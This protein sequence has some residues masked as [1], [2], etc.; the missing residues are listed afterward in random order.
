M[1]M[2]E[3][4]WLEVRHAWRTLAARPMHTSL[5][6]LTL[7]LG[8]GGTAAIA[9]VAEEALLR[10]LPYE[11]DV[12]LVAFWGPEDWSAAD[13]TSLRGRFDG[14]DD[15]AAWRPEESTL[16]TGD[17]PA[18]LIST[19][20]G[21]S[22][23]FDVLGV[24]PVMGRAFR[25]G[26]D[27]AGAE[28][29]TVVSNG[30]WVR[31]L[32]GVPD[33]LGRRITLDGVRRTIVGVMPREFSFP[34]PSVE[35]WRPL[36]LDPEDNAGMLS[37]VGR[38]SPGRDP[39]AMTSEATRI[40]EKVTA[41]RPPSDR[42][43]N[44]T[45]D[46][47]L[48]PL[49]TALRG[50]I[51]PTLLL[52]GGAMVLILL[53]A[54][55]NVAA[56]TTARTSGRVGELSLRMALG[57]GRGRLAR[58]LVVES[59]L[60]ALLGGI[61]GAVIAAGSF[62]FLTAS[63]PTSPGAPPQLDLRL[64][65]FSML[66]AVV[67]GVGVGLFPAGAILRDKLGGMA[68]PARTG[69]STGRGRLA[70]GLVV[71]EVALAVLLVSGAALLLRSV[72]ELA[73]IDLGFEPVGLTS[74]DIVMGGGEMEQDERLR[75]LDAV[76]QR[77]EALPGVTSVASVQKLPLRGRGWTTSFRVENQPDERFISAFRSVTPEY[78]A[79][80]GIGTRQGRT[81]AS[82]DVAESEPVV[83]VNQTLARTL[84]PGESALGK[85]VTSGFTSEWATVVGVVEDVRVS[86]L[87]DDAVGVRYQ[88]YRQDG[89]VPEG[90]TLVVRFSRRPTGLIEPV[91]AAIHDVDPRIA[92]GR[93]A[94]LET[95]ARE[96]RGAAGEIVLLLSL[97]GGLALALGAIGVY[98]I[99]ANYVGQRTREWGVRLA[100]GREPARLVVLILRRGLLAGGYGRC[101]G[102]AVGS[103]GIAGP[104]GALVRGRPP[105][106]RC[107]RGRRRRSRGHR[108]HFRADT[109]PEGRPHRPRC[110]LER[111]MSGGPWLAG[112]P[113]ESGSP[114]NSQRIGWRAKIRRLAAKTEAP[115]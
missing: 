56:L 110:V 24:A 61:A 50:D 48:T 90:N 44:G 102:G 112:Q 32:G 30:F 99:T 37:L 11:D 83:V 95:I 108:G 91:R 26:D 4:A 66:I 70:S 82:F 87:T 86:A 16:R 97:L 100:L 80:M 46:A 106:P 75:T 1:R 45:Q 74:F 111:R 21:S 67:A 60:V 63:F 39:A 43:G 62:S 81:T 103:H 22:E 84:W 93:V 10:P 8:V 76:V 51:G 107:P 14:M 42:R 36:E 5:S 71:V 40:R 69:V 109:R 33:V 17:G 58:Q 92:I 18:R 35:L 52:V 104:G 65:G 94:S 34:D 6:V 115:T 23:L 79:T 7:S 114:G 73:A 12:S 96:A 29:V 105:R 19:A 101:R 49:R 25:P 41:A 3:G 68:D 77:L 72:Q 98:G 2:L 28:P 53:V 78:F 15:V 20:S 9:S 54:C 13:F 59:T 55:A 88:L 38:V 27:E 85:R 31:E 57:A 64:F 89:V 113:S 47:E